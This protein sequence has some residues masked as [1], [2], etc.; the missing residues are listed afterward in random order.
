MLRSR[1][2]NLFLAIVISV[3]SFGTIGCDDRVKDAM[4]P[5][6]FDGLDYIAASLLAGLEAE[7]HPD[8]T[9]TTSS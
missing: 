8:S 6:L 3:T 7:I 2:R 4:V 1:V 9:T 5:V